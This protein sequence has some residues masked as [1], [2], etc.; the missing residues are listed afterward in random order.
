M[1]LTE[2]NFTKEVCGENLPP[3]TRGFAPI[4]SENLDREKYQYTG[5]NFNLGV[6]VAEIPCG[7]G[8]TLTS[9]GLIPGRLE[10]ALETSC[11]ITKSLFKH[12]GYHTDKILPGVEV[13]L[14]LI[15]GYSVVHR[16]NVAKVSFYP[17]FARNSLP[18]MSYCHT[19]DTA[20]ANRVN[21]SRP[22]SEAE[23]KVALLHFAATVTRLV[24]EVCSH[25]N[26]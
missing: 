4:A 21:D 20:L 16:G 10:Q 23:T 6:E 8:L 17:S 14:N 13:T 12:G 7:L 1:M 24:T 22:L 19:K 9:E 26:F 15:V 5:I 11:A 18:S 3:V 2:T 25:N